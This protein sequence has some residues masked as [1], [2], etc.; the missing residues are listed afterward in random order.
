MNITSPFSSNA[1]IYVTTVNKVTFLTFIFQS[2]LLLAPHDKH[3]VVHK[4]QVL[5][6]K[7]NFPIHS[8]LILNLQDVI[9]KVMLHETISNNR[10]ANVE[11]Y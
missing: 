8:V 1:V 6:R 4:I 5:P 2:T 11:K 3:L 9:V 10:W 7:T